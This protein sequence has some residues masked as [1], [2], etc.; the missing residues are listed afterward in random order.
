[1]PVRLRRLIIFGT[2]TIALMSISERVGDL[3]TQ[4]VPVR[5]LLRVLDDLVLDDA[6]LNKNPVI[7]LDIADIV[8]HFT[9]L[10]Q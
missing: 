7:P 8:D 4:W 10:Q 6:Q 2:S 5:C 3:H 9:C 1:M